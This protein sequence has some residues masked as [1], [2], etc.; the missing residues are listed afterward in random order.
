LFDLNGTLSKGAESN[1]IGLTVSQTDA[2]AR[3]YD[4][5]KPYSSTN[6]INGAVTLRANA[7]LASQPDA[8]AVITVAST[9]YSDAKE[10]PTGSVDVTLTSGAKVLKI[11]ALEADNTSNDAV[12]VRITSPTG[13]LA[14]FT[15][16]PKSDNGTSGVIGRITAEGAQI[17][18]IERRTNGLLIVKYPDGSFETLVQ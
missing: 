17:A 11:N 14:L 2:S 4:T 9:G 1:S 8:L 18:T 12:G 5:S 3:A 6:F 16:L 13:A 7:K 10:R 15:Y